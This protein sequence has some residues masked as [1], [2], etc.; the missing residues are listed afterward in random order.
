MAPV[1]APRHAGSF[2]SPGRGFGATRPPARRGATQREEPTV[3]YPCT[4]CNKCGAYS[5]RA[6][7]VCADCG[8]E[9]KPGQAACPD[10]GGRTLTA[11]KLEPVPPT[12]VGN[13]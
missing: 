1:L 7:F 11:V 2:T 6:M 8:A 10:C 3:C 13:E 9:V 5:A 12:P 4:H